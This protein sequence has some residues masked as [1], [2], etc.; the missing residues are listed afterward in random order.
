MYVEILAAVCAAVVA[1]DVYDVSMTQK[2]L[3]AGVAVE[4]F[5]WLVGS[6]PSALA[7]YLR[8]TLCEALSIAPTVFCHLAGADPAAYGLLIA[9]GV[10][11]VK[12]VL[13]GLAWKKLLK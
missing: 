1:S 3:K 12:H 6:K 2:G 13:G 5:T 11:A 7:L 8:D 10:Y 9:P 4:G